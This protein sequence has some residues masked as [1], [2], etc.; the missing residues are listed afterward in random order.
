MKSRWY[1]MNMLALVA[2]AA[3]GVNACGGDTDSS[4]NNDTNAANDTNAGADTSAAPTPTP[5]ST[6]TASGDSSATPT[7]TPTDTTAASSDSTSSD[8]STD[9]SSSDATPTPTPTDTTV[10]SDPTPTPTD[11]ATPDV[12]PTPTPTQSNVPNPG[13]DGANAPTPPPAPAVP[14]HLAEEGVSAINKTTSL[15]FGQK[16]SPINCTSGGTV[17][18]AQPAGGESGTFTFTFSNCA[19]PYAQFTTAD[20]STCAFSSTLSGTITCTVASNPD[21]SK[22]AHCVTNSA[23]DGLTLTIGTQTTTFGLVNDAAIGGSGTSTETICTGTT[24]Y[25]AENLSLSSFNKADLVCQ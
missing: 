5:T 8:T 11:S 4:N 16:T 9:T 14:A 20:S 3:L 19:E 17:T 6:D 12:T 15:Y 23:C 13:D 22:T 2:V 10:A 21:G 7:P 24:S 25:D 18:T 1:T